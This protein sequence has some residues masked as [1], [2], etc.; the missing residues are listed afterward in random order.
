[1]IARVRFLRKNFF[2]FTH[3]G[4]MRDYAIR[5]TEAELNCIRAALARLDP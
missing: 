5:I 4:T 3:E 2:G 1:M